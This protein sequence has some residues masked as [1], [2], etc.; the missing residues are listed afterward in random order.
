MLSLYFIDAQT[1]EAT[2]VDWPIER[3]YRKY[4][5]VEEEAGTAAQFAGPSLTQGR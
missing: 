4:E 3:G 5:E 1:I 2:Q